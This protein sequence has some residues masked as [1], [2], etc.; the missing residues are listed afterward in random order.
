MGEEHSVLRSVLDDRV[1]DRD[2]Q[3]DG[4]DGLTPDLLAAIVRAVQS[5]IDRRPRL[6]RLMTQTEVIEALRTS[7]T[8]F[9]RLR[10]GQIPN[11]RPFP[12]PR[13]VGTHPRWIASEV[14]AWIEEST[15]RPV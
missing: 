9:H 6:P 3:G 7:R 8:G 1:R 12:K 10:T 11:A 4:P 2:R 15:V 14:E 5:E 13:Y